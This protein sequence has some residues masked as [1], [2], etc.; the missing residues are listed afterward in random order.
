MTIHKINPLPINWLDSI[1]KFDPNEVST[2]GGQE[3]ARILKNFVLEK[4]ESIIGSV[5]I[6]NFIIW[7]LNSNKEMFQDYGFIPISII[8]EVFSEIRREKGLGFCEKLDSTFIELIAFRDILKKN[9]F[10]IYKTSRKSGSSDFFIKKYCLKY[11][12]EVKFK[13][14]DQ[15][16]HQ[17]IEYLLVGK[18]MVTSLFQKKLIGK[19]IYVNIKIPPQD[20]TNSVKKRIYEKVEKWSSSELNDFSDEDI[21]ITIRVYESHNGF[22]AFECSDKT[23]LGIYPEPK[24]IVSIL[25][26]NLTRIKEQFQKR[27]PQRSIGIVVWETPWNYN[28]EEKEK[29]E[30]LIITGVHDAIVNTD[31]HCDRLY[32]YPTGLKKILCCKYKKGEVVCQPTSV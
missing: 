11:E 15:A 13:R 10:S 1:K 20:I 26:P 25:S 9:G 22:T 21:D 12:A 32:I 31:I 5:N 30:S 2:P 27:R 19:R 24:E 8:Q 7:V 3:I 29:M 28:F 18:S 14:A 16:L 23:R 17:S 4:K 6:Q